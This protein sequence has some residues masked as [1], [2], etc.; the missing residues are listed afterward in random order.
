MRITCT[1]VAERD[2]R[3]P[4]QCPALA[5][6]EPWEKKVPSNQLITVATQEMINTSG[7]LNNSYNIEDR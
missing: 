5:E 7:Q 2:D 1:E 4:L 3:L 6:R